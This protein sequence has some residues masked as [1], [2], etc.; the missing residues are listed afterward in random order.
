MLRR[1]AVIVNPM[2]AD[3]DRLRA[4]VGVEEERADWAPS[5]WW[6]T[7]AGDPGA[8]AARAALATEPALVIVAGGDGTIRAVVEEVHG[9]GIPIAVVPVGTG[10]LL[11][12]NLG[13]MADIETA[14][15][16]A[17]TGSARVIDVGVVELTGDDGR[18]WSHRF[19]VMA[20]VGLDAKMATGTDSVLKKRIG[21]LAYADPISKS[22]MG[23]EQFWI[24]YRVDSGRER[25]VRAHTVIV[26]NCSTLTAGFVLLPDAVPDDQ[27]L[28]VVL[29]RPKGF[30]QWVRVGS[31]LGIGAVLHRTKRGRVILD[32]TP[33]L[34]ALQYVQARSVAARFDEPQHVELDGDGFG[35]VTAVSV[36]LDPVGLTI[37]VPADPTA[38]SPNPANL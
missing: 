9:R 31:R 38:A 32:A 11:A 8:A 25:S 23:N 4:A 14:V 3:V 10:N 15:H 7:T 21:W 12:R 33:D 28:D 2:T 29:L 6:E 20:G 22:V 24:H 13:L 1:A 27:L 18:V 17:W 5:E 26:G 37:R 35:A 30:W 19:L 36:S 34:R 16:T